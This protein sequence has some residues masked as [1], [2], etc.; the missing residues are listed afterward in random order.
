[1]GKGATS[2]ESRNQVLTQQDRNHGKENG[3]KSGPPESEAT[4]RLM[5]LQPSRHKDTGGQIVRIT[6]AQSYDE[7]GAS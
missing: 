2:D 3:S 6:A 7:T 5:S 4:Q 1:M